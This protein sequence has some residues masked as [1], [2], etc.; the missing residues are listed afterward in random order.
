MLQRRIQINRNII[1]DQKISCNIL[2]LTET[3]TRANNLT[4]HSGP[5]D[6]QNILYCRSH[7]HA[8]EWP[9]W[10]VWSTPIVIK[11]ADSEFGY[12]YHRSLVERFTFHK[13]I[14]YFIDL[15][16]KMLNDWY[17]VRPPSSNILGRFGK[18]FGLRKGK[19]SLKF[20]CVVSI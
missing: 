7:Q 8:R 1:Y 10:K 20:F 18:F 15:V 17:M 2:P 19:I 12:Q 11:V 6:G 16:L 5:Y 9:I 14:L 13:I 3:L 4:H